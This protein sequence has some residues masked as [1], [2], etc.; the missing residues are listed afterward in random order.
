MILFLV[1][2]MIMAS[3][4]GNDTTRNQAYLLIVAVGALS[5]LM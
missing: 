4:I 3:F 5:L 2:L 1:I